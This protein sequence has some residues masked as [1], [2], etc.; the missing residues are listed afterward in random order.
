MPFR[1]SPLHS[2][3][4]D[5]R[6]CSGWEETKNPMAANPCGRRVWLVAATLLVVFFRA[7]E[8]R[9]DAAAMHRADSA[10]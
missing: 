5:R 2:D 9:G 4:A 8:P 6:N 3:S 1:D 10:R 7:H